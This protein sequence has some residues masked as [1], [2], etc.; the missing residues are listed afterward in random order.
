[1]I[2]MLA[3]EAILRFSTYEGLQLMLA[4]LFMVAKEAILRFSTYEGLQLMLA[5][6]FMDEPWHCSNQQKNL[7]KP[8]FLR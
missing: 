7:S 6:L 2:R 4:E 1:M 5:E 3:K 8:Q